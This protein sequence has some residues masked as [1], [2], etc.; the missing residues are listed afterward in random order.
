M[1]LLN[2]MLLFS[3]VCELDGFI[4]AQ[5]FDNILI[6]GYFNVDFSRHVHN[7]ARLLDFMN[8]HNL[9]RAD[10]SSHSFLTERMITVFSL[11]DHIL[12]LRHNVSQVREVTCLDSVDNFSD[13][14]PIFFFFPHLFSSSTVST[15]KRWSTC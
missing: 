5:S 14:L 8:D 15:W 1:G 10:T 6:C 4:S 3:I 11:H 9:V 13:H 12:I 2:P 7:T